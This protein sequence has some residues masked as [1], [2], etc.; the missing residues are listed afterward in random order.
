M[1]KVLIFLIIVMSTGVIASAIPV[2]LSPGMVRGMLRTLDGELRKRDKY[3]AQRSARIDS[4]EAVNRALPDDAP[5]KLTAVMELADAY[6]GYLA[7]SALVNYRRGAE[8]AHSQGEPEWAMRFSLYALAS[9]PL[10]GYGY[11]GAQRYEAISPDSIDA[12]ML[13]V[14][15]DR[16][17]QLYDYQASF[18]MSSD[19][20]H[21]YWHSKAIDTEGKLLDVLPGNSSEYILRKAEYLYNTGRSV[22]A[23]TLLGDLLDSQP[24][25]CKESAIAANLLARIFEEHG[26][27]DGQIYYLAMSAISDLRN[28]TREMVSLQELGAALYSAGDINRAYTC[29][30]TALSNA[31][32][33]KASM[34]MLQASELLPVIAAAHRDTL[35]SHKRWLWSGLVLLGLALIVL[36][37]M[38]VRLQKNMRRMK[39][40]KEVLSGANR[41]KEMYM[42]QFLNL[43]TVYM[44]KLNRFCK[45]AE[46]KISTGHTDDLYRLVKSGKFVEEQSREFYDTFDRTFLHIYPDFVAEVN[47]LLNPDEQIELKD[48]E[49]LNTDMRILAF[50]RLGV[51]ESTR[52]AQV[53]NYSVHTIYAYRN[54]LRNRA[55]NRDTFDA[56]VMNIGRIADTPD[57][58]P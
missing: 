41:I 39:A 24:L 10:A 29:L 17:R 28:A 55:I 20:E 27:S 6:D 53:L 45:V 48:G 2:E 57:R 43:C 51:E 3:L 4:L 30:S 58:K 31:V 34:R 35:E 23:M 1:K 33:C 56:D 5:E 49:M 11:V 18:F 9:T 36:I 15:Y 8:L 25:E 37:L 16:G 14:F 52:I 7:D 32:E 40:L 42:S 46:R 50:M 26:N 21:E 47:K 54:R 19:A 12:D 38:V 13:A 44:D 22:E